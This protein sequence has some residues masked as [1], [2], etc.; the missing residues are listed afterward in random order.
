MEHH[1]TSGLRHV[2]LPASDIEIK[3]SATLQHP[4]QEQDESV[5]TIASHTAGT[6]TLDSIR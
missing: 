4:Q 5:K 3:A 2:F 1:A 6:T